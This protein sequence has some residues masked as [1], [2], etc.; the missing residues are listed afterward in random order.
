[1]SIGFGLGNVDLV[2]TECKLNK[3][4]FLKAVLSV[5]SVD[6]SSQVKNANAL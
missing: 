3:R 6:L 2:Q 1:M 4:S 5:F